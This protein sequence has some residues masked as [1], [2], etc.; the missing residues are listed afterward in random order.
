[1]QFKHSHLF[2]GDNVTW[3]IKYFILSHRKFSDV[4]VHKY[5]LT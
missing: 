1:M 4:T 2:P 3:K 5:V